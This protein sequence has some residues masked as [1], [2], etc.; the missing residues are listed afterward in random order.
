MDEGSISL[1]YHTKLRTRCLIVIG[2]MNDDSV[3]S[4]VA[5]ILGAT[6]TSSKPPRPGVLPMEAVRIQSA[7]AYALLEVV[8]NYLVGLK[9]MEADFVLGGFPRSGVFKGKHTTDEF[10]ATIWEE[11]SNNTLKIWNS[12]RRKPLNNHTLK[13]MASIWLKRRISRA[14][15]L[16]QHEILKENPEQRQCSGDVSL[17]DSARTNP[18]K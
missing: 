18:R 6:I 11:F 15:G 1:A 14:R 10:F 5:R 12:K 13:E 3:L 17:P 8:Q 7:K 4:A 2:S 9:R 16:S